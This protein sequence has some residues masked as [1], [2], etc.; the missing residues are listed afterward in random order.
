[1]PTDGRD[2]DDE[3]HTET[4]R[5]FETLATRAGEHDGTSTDVVPPLHL[6][7]TF[8]RETM[9]TEDADYRYS[10]IDNPTRRGLESTLAALEGGD[11]AFAFAS[12]TSAIATTIL[13]LARPGGHVVAFENLYG[14]TERLLIELFGEWLDVDIKF[15]DA[16]DPSTVED[17]IRPETDLVWIETP[18]NP[19][20]RL[21]DIEAVAAAVDPHDVPLGVDNTF[22]S[23]YFQNPLERGADV[24]VHSTTKYLNGHSDSLGGVAVTSDETIAGRL[25][26]A[27]RIGLGNPLAPFDA[28][29]VARGIRTLPV[30]MDRHE[31]NAL[32]LARFLEAQDSI[33][34]VHYPGLESHPQHDL[35]TRQAQGFGG[36]LSFEFDGTVPETVAVLQALDEFSLAVSLGGVES[37]VELPSE[38]THEETTGADVGTTDVPDTLVR[39]SVGLEHV[40]DLVADFRAAL[41]P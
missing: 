11:E 16:R 12:G 34:Q 2:E 23:P 37:L 8:V 38:M 18:T 40:D 21:C 15:V 36:V 4:V 13:A 28:Y 17:A 41:P 26:F 30:R 31:S 6:S 10:R 1:M 33:R 9:T 22:M 14:G 27:Q 29:F 25:E 5:H 20:L 39:V 35:A 32:E 24:V 7:T 19:L 3:P